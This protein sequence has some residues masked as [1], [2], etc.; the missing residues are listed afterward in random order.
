[1]NRRGSHG[2]RLAVLGRARVQAGLR[3]DFWRAM[4]DND[5]GRGN[6][7]DSQA[8]WRDAGKAGVNQGFVGENK[9][10]HFEVAVTTLLPA[11][12]DSTWK[13]IYKIYGSGDVIASGT[14]TT[15]LPVCGPE[16]ASPMPETRSVVRVRRE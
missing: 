5:R 16:V 3:P 9:A 6:A 10:D 12:S 7:R 13:T 4:T 11:A 1:M 8:Y 2:L 14:Q 15:A